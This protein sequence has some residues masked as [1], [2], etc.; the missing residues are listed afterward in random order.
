[1]QS[2]ISDNY[3]YIDEFNYLVE[4]IDLEFGSK[5]EIRH[6]SC[7]NSHISLPAK[8]EADYSEKTY[9]AIVIFDSGRVNAIIKH[10]EAELALHRYLMNKK[11]YQQELFLLDGAV[12]NKVV[13]QNFVK[14]LKVLLE[15]DSIYFYCWEGDKRYKLQ[16]NIK[17]KLKV[18]EF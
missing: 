7:S 16:G 3:K 12:E 6:M 15:D 8:I 13:L 1:M 10:G 17:K 9:T 4:L 11:Q 18:G 14:E 2:L 5:L